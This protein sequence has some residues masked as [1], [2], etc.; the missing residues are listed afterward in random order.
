[1]TSQATD[2]LNFNLDNKSNTF[3]LIAQNKMNFMQQSNY[4]YT[5]ETRYLELSRAMKIC[6]R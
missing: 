5:V 1:M 4:L 6:S 2:C 3:S